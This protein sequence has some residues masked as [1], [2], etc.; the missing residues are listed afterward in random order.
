[1]WQGPQGAWPAHTPPVKVLEEGTGSV[2]APPICRVESST[3]LKSRVSFTPASATHQPCDLS[4]VHVCKPVSS[5]RKWK[6]DS[7]RQSPCGARAC[8]GCGG[9]PLPSWDPARGPHCTSKA[10][11]NPDATAGQGRCGPACSSCH[12]SP[13]RTS[14][15]GR[16]SVPHRPDA[17]SFLGRAG[18][19]C[20]RG[21][22]PSP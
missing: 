6:G 21:H 19:S 22:R 16:H 2:P 4:A 3:S 10:R 14:S 13:G 9:T 1:M 18:R 8:S 7:I 5:G 15:A 20:W 17:S 11:D 12:R